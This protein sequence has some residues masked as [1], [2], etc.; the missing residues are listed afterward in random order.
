M[1]DSVGGQFG[2]YQFSRPNVRMVCND[3]LGGV[4]NIS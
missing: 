4:P 1:N 2:E 3:R